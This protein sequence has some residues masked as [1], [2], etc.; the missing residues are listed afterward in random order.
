MQCNWCGKNYTNG[1]GGGYCSRRCYEE[2]HRR[3]CK[4]CG[5]SFTGRGYS[6]SVFGVGGDWCSESCYE[7][8]ASP[9]QK[10]VD[11]VTS[12]VAWTIILCIFCP[13]L[14]LLV[15]WKQVL[16]FIKIVFKIIFSKFFW[17]YV[18]P[19]GV[20]IIVAL[21]YLAMREK[22]RKAEAELKNFTEE[23]HTA[24]E[25]DLSGI[26]QAHNENL[27]LLKMKEEDERR[28]KEEEEAKRKKDCETAMEALKEEQLRLAKDLDVEGY[29]QNNMK[30]LY[31]RLVQ[32]RYELARIQNQSQGTAPSEGQASDTKARNRLK[33]EIRQIERTIR[34]EFEGRQKE[35]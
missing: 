1:Y 3:T 30:E 24:Q 14:L 4:G 33:R 20:V 21:M 35:Q 15:Y 26:V 13:P 28:R 19:I 16:W 11:A 18:V 22:M 7:R 29:A 5:R 23:T 10:K 17:K 27:R 6:G 34:V 25:L 32:L 8:N 31:A 12:K 9:A 2:G